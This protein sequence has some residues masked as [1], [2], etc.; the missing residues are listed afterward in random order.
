VTWHRE[1]H[2]NGQ[3]RV[4]TGVEPNSW[5]IISSDPA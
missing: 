5:T 1:V 3:L 4:K 2:C